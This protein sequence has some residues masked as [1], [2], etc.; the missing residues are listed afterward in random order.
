MHKIDNFGKISGLKLNSNKSIILRSGSLSKS[1]DNFSTGNQF[2]WTSDYASTLGI[3]FS[4]DKR[5]YNEY[6]L[7]PNKQNFATASIY[8]QKHNFSLIGKI[9]VIKTFAL[10]K[11]IYHL[12]FQKTHQKKL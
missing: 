5:M 8:V 7:N 10:P 11:L 3:T 6:N 4:N 2:V 9:T 12:R 1:K